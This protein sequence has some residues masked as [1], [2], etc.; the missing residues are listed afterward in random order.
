MSSDI[1]DALPAYPEE[2]SPPP[3]PS[4]EPRPLPL[5]PNFWWALA[6]CLALLI[7]TQICAPIVVVLP[8]VFYLAVA[9]PDLFKDGNASTL[10]ESTTMQVALGFAQWFA[11]LMIIVMSLVVLRVVAGRE[12][13]REV[14][15]RR[16]SVWHLVLVILMWPAFLVFANGVAWSL[17]EVLHFPSTK[18]VGGLMAFLSA[19]VTM[20]LLTGLLWALLSLV[21]GSNWS[22]RALGPTPS[23]RA[24]LLST[25]LLVFC[26]GQAVFFYQ[27][28]RSIT[29]EWRLPSDQG[30]FMSEFLKQINSWPL[31]VAIFVIGVMPGL[32]EEL[33][34]RAYLGRG[35]VGKHGVWWGVILT[36]FL[37]GFIHID[38]LQGTMATT[39]GLILHYVY[40]TTRS[41]WMP[42]LLHFLNNSLSVTLARI[43]QLVQ[44]EEG[45]STVP[46]WYLAALLGAAILVLGTICYALYETR[47]RLMT[48]E[49]LPAWEPPYPGV[50]CPPAHSATY[51]GTT[52][53][54]FSS[55]LAVLLSM[56]LFVAWTVVILWQVF[57]ETA[58]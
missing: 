34:C 12:W 11:H 42:M 26:V 27:V 6:W 56:A 2:P 44:L 53:P 49:G 43:P 41:L 54:R 17:S 36:S 19:L 40:I 22:K 57:A 25:L 9:E 29:G 16:P 1:L 38:P 3:L 21:F 39:V 47:A 51:V 28:F 45:Q 4:T 32:S 18:D 10:L 15:L 5:H 20:L 37:F 8:F 55:V 50:A 58:L 30:D 35:L 52:A 23:W 48:P 24:F 14:A 46:D 33:W 13:K 7:I 31:G